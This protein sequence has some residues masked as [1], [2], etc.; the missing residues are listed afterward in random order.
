MP[1]ARVVGGDGDVFL[2][3]GLVEL[4]HRKAARIEEAVPAPS[5]S[6]LSVRCGRRSGSS[7]IVSGRP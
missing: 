2:S 1:V 4:P 3:L 5:T 6:R 7:A